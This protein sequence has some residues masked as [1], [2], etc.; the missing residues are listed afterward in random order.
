L[1]EP[2]DIII[3]NHPILALKQLDKINLE[4]RKST[5]SVEEE[6]L[7]LLALK[8]YQFVPELFASFQSQYEINFL[9]E[10]CPGGDLFEKLNRFGAFKE[11][12][13][14][15]YIAQVA[16]ILEYLHSKKIIYR[17]L[18][19][20]N[21]LFDSEGYLKLA[22]FGCSKI[23]QERV[24]GLGGTPEYMSP[25]MILD[26]Q[27]GTGYGK[28]ID[29]WALGC[30]MYEMLSGES[31]FKSK[32]NSKLFEKILDEKIKFN[33]QL[34]RNA[35][36]LLKRLLTKDPIKRVSFNEIKKHSFFENFDWEELSM[37]KLKAPFIPDIHNDFGISNFK[38][39]FV[40][41]DLD[42]VFNELK[43]DLWINSFN[44]ESEKIIRKSQA[45]G[46]EEIKYDS[47]MEDQFEDKMGRCGSFSEFGDD[48][49]WS[50]NLK[51]I[52]Y[53]Y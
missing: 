9:M 22:D 21:L 15:F 50:E 34:S 17:D 1:V 41:M 52:E 45:I 2:I 5:E 47:L 43:S 48:F 12:E 3:N 13:V 23:G 28:E 19:P 36:N 44:F 29:W 37:K 30:L 33:I 32:K 24:S 11:N 18:K 40:N 27:N 46:I 16:L 35:E 6:K 4:H 31:L 7:I 8:D 26:H 51:E 25:E 49:E 39:K 14:R 20:E 53:Y 38:D 42:L 10:F